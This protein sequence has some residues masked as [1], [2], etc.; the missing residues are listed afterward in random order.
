MEQAI[1]G[2]AV[3]PFDLREVVESCWRA[4]EDIY[5]DRVFACRLEPASAVVRGSPEWLAPLLD[6]LVDN[7]VGFSAEGSQIDI[8]LQQTP[9]EF[10]LA[11]TNRGS[12]LPGAMR[13]ELFDS[14]GA[15]L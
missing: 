4:Y 7:A 2:T 5:P 12:A 8:T 13:R 10:C 3:E 9:S 11:V 1:N 15:I 6:T 14:L